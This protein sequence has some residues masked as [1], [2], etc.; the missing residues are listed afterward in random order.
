MIDWANPKGKVS[1]YFTVHD[2]LYLPKWDRLANVSDGLTDHI[3]L[4]LVTL[5]LKMDVVRLFLGSPIIPHVTY[6]PPAYNKLI[7]GA[8]ESAHMCLGNYAA[9]DFHAFTFDCDNV[10]GKLVPML[11]QYGMRM[12]NRPQSNWVHMDTKP[13]PTG[14]HRF[15]LP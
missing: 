8:S 6:R 7:G 5:A 3:K 4:H 13:P 1:T 15:F 11:E 12:E 14:G 9:M 10:R 2:L